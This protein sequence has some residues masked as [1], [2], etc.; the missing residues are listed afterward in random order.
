MKRKLK[1]LK[2]NR[3]TVRNMNAEQLGRVAGGRSEG[4]EHCSDACTFNEC[5]V[6]ESWCVCPRCKF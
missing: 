3:E 1:K 5:T 6:G 2:L 4:S